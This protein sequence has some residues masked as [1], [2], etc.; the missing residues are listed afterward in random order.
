MDIK[1][2]RR[3]ICHK[4]THISTLLVDRLSI[5]PRRC[6]YWLNDWH[7]TTELAKWLIANNIDPVDIYPGAP[8]TRIVVIT[9]LGKVIWVEHPETGKP[10]K[11]ELPGRQIACW[12][13]QRLLDRQRRR[14]RFG[15]TFKLSPNVGNFC[16][17]V[18]LTAILKSIGEYKVP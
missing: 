9:T 10:M 5:D 1:T 16:F 6:K 13:T 4:V 18:M 12:P 7:G 3:S 15:A 17:S 8:D 2:L 11:K 14:M